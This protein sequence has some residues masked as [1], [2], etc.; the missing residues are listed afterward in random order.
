[1]NALTLLFPHQLF[2]E[3]P[4]VGDTRKVLLVEERLFFSQYCF[5]KQ[6]LAFHRASMKWYEAYLEKLGREVEYV[7][8]GEPES[9]IR[10]LVP[11]LHR[12]GVTDL[13][14]LDPTD[15]WLRR[16]LHD[17]AGSAG[18][19]LTEYDT[20]MFLNTRR[21]LERYFEGQ[22]TYYH[23]DFYAEQRKKWDILVDDDDKPVGGKWSYDTENRSK[24]P[25]GKS[26]PAIQWPDPNEYYREA[27][28]YVEEQ[29]PGNYGTLDSPVQYPVTYRETS[30]WLDQF[31]ERRF[32]EFG[33]Y[34]DAIVK[35]ET[36]LHH[37]VL[38]PMLNTGL[39]TPKAVLDR[40]LE[41]AGSNEIPLNTLEGFIRQI[42]GWREY[43]RA[44]YELEGRRERTENFWHFDRKIPASFWE[45]TTG[46]GPVDAV[47]GRVLE[48][49]YAHHI[50][51]LMVLGNFMLL[52][53][54]DP[55]EVYRW[56][57]E[58]FVDAYDWVMV[59]NV[60]GM[61]QFADGGLM[62]TKPYISSSN[63]IR[64]MSN[65]GKGP[66]A[67][68]WDGLFWRFMHKHRA[69]FEQN[70]RMGMLIST[71]DRMGDDTLAVHIQN[72]EKFLD[73]L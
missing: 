54:F 30:K 73:Q 58:L 29:F 36:F 31:L 25:R 64:K 19:E 62:A 13:H 60:Y 67:D 10:E 3:N 20:P 21:D 22:N 42:L 6:K 2:E 1:M 34:Q 32:R 71:M 59:P 11:E 56:F 61:S 23:A 5:H 17:A 15:D 38:T 48:T 35:D 14:I 28:Q 72:A 43:I 24:Y 16:R 33:D 26:P 45:G 27:K 46:I 41:Y 51:R 12:R 53:E 39:I 18:L 44:V 50:E 57:M 66:W 7:E 55:D 65:F 68:T 49:G 63:Y 9:D 4:A 47:I 52:C 37:S 69:Y 8:C 70:H 40:T